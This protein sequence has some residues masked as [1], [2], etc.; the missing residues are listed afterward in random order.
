VP[1][2]S[3]GVTRV[4]D[5]A[6]AT[7]GT[8]PDFFWPF[9]RRLV[10]LAGIRP[11]DEVLDVATGT[12][13]VALP[14][15]EAR[16]KVV[17][18]DLSAAMVERARRHGIDAHVADAQALPF[19]DASFDHVL[20]GFGLFFLP[21][22]PRGLGEIHR[23]LRPRGVLAF[24]AF[25]GRDPRWSW[26]GELLPSGR[27][28]PVS[29][30]FGERESIAELLARCGFAE[31]TFHEET[32]ELEFTDADEWWRWV[33]S[34]GHRG[35]LERLSE[36]ERTAFQAAAY[37]RIAAMDR[38]VNAVSARFTVARRG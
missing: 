37:E 15:L 38:I 20:C 6:A 18:I 3:D 25:A 30:G 11:G 34:H 17:G 26:I 9:G 1:S 32:L 22:P 2:G 14:A 36:D 12:G 23:V 19:A 29:A 16:G 27:T 21:D 10:E 8:G 31:P 28:P 24:S 35:V 33:W 7:Y 13:A 4:F 5:A